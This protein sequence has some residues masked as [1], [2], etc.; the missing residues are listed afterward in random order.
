M[1]VQVFVSSS[2]RPPVATPS[3]VTPVK[4]AILALLAGAAG[5]PSPAAAQ[6]V[7]SEQRGVATNLPIPRYVSLKSGTVNMRRGPAREHAAV[8]TY[9]MAGLPVEITGEFENWRKIRDWEG[10]EGWV[11][12]TLLSGRRTAMVAPWQKKGVLELRKSPDASATLVARLGPGVYGKVRSCDRSWCRFTGTIGG[13][14][15]DGYIPQKQ[16]WG[17]YPDENVK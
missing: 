7:M 4:I 8:W 6:K 10:S 9:K 14:N 12:H 3:K 15:F 11:L 5:L 1:T 2:R 17:V 16:L 13:K